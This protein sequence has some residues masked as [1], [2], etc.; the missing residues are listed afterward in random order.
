MG[1]MPVQTGG[2]VMV[3]WEGTK[4]RVQL[5]MAKSRIDINRGKKDNE[6]AS[7][8]RV[9]AGH[10]EEKKEPLARIQCERVLRERTQIIAF[11][12]LETYIDIMVKYNNAF[13]QCRDFNML[14]QN[15]KS[16]VASLVFAHSRV[17]VPELEPVVAMLRA[18]FGAQ[19][20]DPF[21]SMTG[22]N[23]TLIDKLLAHQLSGNPPDGHLILKELQEIAHE[24]NVD[25]QP[26]PEESD[27]HTFDY[28]SGYQHNFDN[29]NLPPGPPP[30]G[31]PPPHG[32]D[33][34]YGASAPDPSVFNSMAAPAMNIPGFPQP[35]GAQ[36]PMDPSAPQFGGG[37]GGPPFG[38]PPPAVPF[39]GPPPTA[40][41]GFPPPPPPPGNGMGNHSHY[42]D[43]ELQ[44]KL[45]K[46]K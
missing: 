5:K 28:S 1:A 45:N 26:P 23:I 4:C 27:L 16:A 35:G 32:G 40:P 9:I 19:E 39:G 34:A 20:I 21:I 14:Q 36:F 15:L 42:T 10:L 30:F 29:N 18:N 7:I 44:D 17:N 2:P 38:G 12:I 41:H 43:Q 6:I 8:R 3:R 24:Y 31:G 37:G 22:P 11:D 25:W 13:E 33:N 46:F